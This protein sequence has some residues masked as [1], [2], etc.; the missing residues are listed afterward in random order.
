MTKLIGNTLLDAD[1]PGKRMTAPYALRN[2]DD[3]L[4]SVQHDLEKFT[5]NNWA[6]RQLNRR[7]LQGI[8][9]RLKRVLFYLKY[10]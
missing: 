8:R 7:A 6:T 5:T 1:K 4:R 10:A 2:A 9:A 3:L